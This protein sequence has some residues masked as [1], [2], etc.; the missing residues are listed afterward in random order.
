MNNTAQAYNQEPYYM[1]AMLKVRTFAASGTWTEA[2][3]GS[4]SSSTAFGTNGNSTATG[5]DW[6]RAVCTNPP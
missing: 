6:M 4:S 2:N 5:R 3:C 1:N